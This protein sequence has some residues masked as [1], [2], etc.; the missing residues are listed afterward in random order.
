MNVRICQAL[1]V[2][3]LL[4]FAWN[5]SAQVQLHG[6]HAQMNM[7]CDTCHGQTR[8]REVPDESVCLTCHVSRDAVKQKTAA[9]K[10]NPHYGHSESQPCGDCHKQ[11]EPSVLTCDQC[12]KFGY[13]TP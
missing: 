6:K 5:A 4:I 2:A 3:G 11:H 7:Q 10:P 9:L 1:C 12:H 8:P 13:K